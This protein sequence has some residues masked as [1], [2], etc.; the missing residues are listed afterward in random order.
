MQN[1]ASFINYDHKCYLF[2]RDVDPSRVD[3]VLGEERLRR[4]EL[5]E[6]AVQAEQQRRRG[7]RFH[8]LVGLPGQKYLSLII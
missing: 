4:P 8:R 7:P 5:L 3:E 6:E 1:L 2:Q